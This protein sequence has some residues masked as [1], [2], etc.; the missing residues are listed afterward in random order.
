MSSQSR[1][2]AGILLVVLPTVIFG[3]VSILSFLI[4][5]ESGYMKNPLRQD[6]WRAGHAH[7]GVFLVLSLVALRYVDE[8]V[9]SNAS[10]NFVRWALPAAAI[11]L[12]VAFFLSVLSPNATEPNSLIY[13]AYAGAVVLAAG[14]LTLGVGLL[15]KATT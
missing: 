1:R 10:K 5:P 3:G 9:L 13:L 4:S 6:L 8:A 14:L 12:P 2:A 15:R 11:L 7:A